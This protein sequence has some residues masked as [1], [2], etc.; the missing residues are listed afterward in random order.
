[1]ISLTIIT[2]WPFVSFS[3]SLFKL[4]LFFVPRFPADEKTIQNTSS[5]EEAKKSSQGYKGQLQR[6]SAQKDEKCKYFV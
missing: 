1:M 2:A 6:E 4:C 3:L 5:G